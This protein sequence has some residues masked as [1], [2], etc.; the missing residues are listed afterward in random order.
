MTKAKLV[1][2]SI[3]PL[4]LATLVG[5]N[6]LAQ[7]QAADAVPDKV[8]FNKQVRPLLSKYC[9]QCHGPDEKV[10]KGGLRLDQKAGAFADLGGRH[11]IVPGNIDKSKLIER[12][13]HSDK[14]KV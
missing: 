12:I 9:Y 4:T 7:P 10:R 14:S 13:T 11:A 2:F 3:L 5:V 8:D 1:R 6:F